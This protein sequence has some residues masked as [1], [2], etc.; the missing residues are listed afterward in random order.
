MGSAHPFIMARLQALAKSRG[1]DSVVTHLD[2]GRYLFE[3]RKRD[4]VGN[5][6]PI[7]RQQ[8]WYRVRQAMQRAGIDSTHHAIHSLRKTSA[9]KMLEAS[10]GSIIAVRDWLH[11]RSSAT[12]DAYL[13]SD[14]FERLRL[15]EK[16][17]AFLEGLAA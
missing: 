17:G 10:G 7:S 1:G 6:R 13:R 8:G 5:S 4:A 2:R 9:R 11:H 14:N 3:S 15:A 16:M 12:T